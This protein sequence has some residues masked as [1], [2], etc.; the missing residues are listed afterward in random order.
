MSVTVPARHTLAKTVIKV[1]ISIFF[2]DYK[3]NKLGPLTF[4]AFVNICLR[5]EKVFKKY[6]FSLYTK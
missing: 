6:F 5:H 1:Q 3:N 2:R 4:A